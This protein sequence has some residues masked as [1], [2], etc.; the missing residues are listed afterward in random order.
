MSKLGRKISI[1]IISAVMA[2]TATTTAFAAQETPIVDENTP[3]AE[4]QQPVNYTK[5]KSEIIPY[6][7]VTIPDT[8][9]L[10][11]DSTNLPY[12][13]AFVDDTSFIP[14]GKKV[15]VK[16]D[17]AGYSGCLTKL[18]VWD[19]RN[20]QEAEYKIYNSDA[21]KNP[22][23]YNIGDEVASWTGSNWG[24]INRKIKLADYRNVGAGKYTGVINYTVSL[25][26]K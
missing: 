17:S 21:A 18:A 6:F 7:T 25:E 12:S 2:A 15:S 3:T 14:S 9:T 24:T 13:L 23:Y 19:S 10:T 1:G 20:L 5:D 16:I 22:T 26:D 8:V 11:K 4:Y